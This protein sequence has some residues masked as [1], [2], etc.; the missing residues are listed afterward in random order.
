MRA[1]RIQQRLW[2]ALI[3]FLILVGGYGCTYALTESDKNRRERIHAANCRHAI[4]EGWPPYIGETRSPYREYEFSRA[5]EYLLS[6]QGRHEEASRIGIGRHALYRYYFDK[7]IERI[8]SVNYLNDDCIKTRDIQFARIDQMRDISYD[9]KSA[10]KNRAISEMHDC[11]Q[12][13]IDLEGAREGADVRA[14][15][16]RNG[17][18]F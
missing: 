16:E 10:L 17:F 4:A 12:K 3:W 7:R 9:R 1:P 15:L 13:L 8:R 2:N 5:A 18:Y 6:C 14:V 11:Q